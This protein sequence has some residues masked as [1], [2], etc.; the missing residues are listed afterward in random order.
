[1]S[2]SPYRISAEDSLG[3]EDEADGDCPDADLFS[4]MSIFWA[5]S[6]ARVA[7]GVLHGEIFG[8]EPTIAF[9]AVL[10]LPFSM[11]ET[12]AWHW[13]RFRR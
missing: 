13:R 2:G 10:L 8:T 4:V 3:L 11:G 12:L 1:M 9:L 6:V 5:F 7:L